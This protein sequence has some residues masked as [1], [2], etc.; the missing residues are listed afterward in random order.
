MAFSMRTPQPGWHPIALVALVALWLSVLPNA[1][2]LRLFWLSPD[3]GGGF[4]R[5]LFT[6]SGWLIS[7]GILLLVGAVLALIFRGWALKAALAAALLVAAPLGY[8][9]WAYSVYF[10]RHMAA[11][12][13]GTHPGE[14][15]EL[16][17]WRVVLWVVLV[18]VLPVWWV[19]RQP[20]R[21]VSWLRQAGLSTALALVGT[22]FV[23]GCIFP[24]YQRFA[25]SL[26][27]G[28]VSFHMLAPVNIVAGFG[29]HWKRT[30]QRPVVAAPRGTD[31]R[32]R[33]GLPQ[34]RIVVFVLGETARAANFSMNG[35]PRETNP[36]MK[37]ASAIYVPGTTSCGTSTAESVPCLF[38]GL[39]REGY[40]NAKAKSQ[41][42]L[43]D[44]V[45][46]SGARVMWRD[47]DSG[48]QGVCASAELEDFNQANH[49]KFCA[50]GECHDEVLLEGLEAKLAQTTKDTLL[51]LHVKG[52]HGPAYFR[53]YPPAF[54]KFQPAC[55][56]KELS[57]CSRE[58]LLNAYDN[59]IL[60]TDHILGEV[61]A[62]LQRLS[63][64]YATMMLYV[65]DHGE[66][67][68]ERGLYLHGA[69]RA[70]APPEQINVPL[71]VW[72]SDTYLKLEKW[73]EACVRK[74]V[75]M[76]PSHDNLYSTILGFM[77]IE[78]KEY[79]AKM[80]LFDH[81]DKR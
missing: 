52:S 27:N 2:F 3:A 72:F 20:L 75:P 35:Y 76:V 46:R 12:I 28:S 33:Y 77:E 24:Q 31:A 7:V 9:S 29:A 43:I 14:A 71:I 22:V 61:T 62:M 39:G 41:E 19:L 34:P 55:Q 56:S 13:L 40:S 58:E 26:R 4:A 44:V 6:A 64:R 30:H 63:D 66:S 15:F 36:R 48:C 8:F 11:N 42:T 79:D 25:S 81:C 70:F 45:R 51:V 78:T 60:Y 49:P 17:G 10:N 1:P 53:R 54:A 37:A 23:L 74:P 32:P 16:I 67:L 5:L 21:P 80:D 50:N 65:S 59:T 47:N 57:A 18:G 68:G 38:S 69:P 73:G